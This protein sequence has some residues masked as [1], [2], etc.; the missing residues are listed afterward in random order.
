MSFTLDERL[1]ADT[2]GILEFGL[3]SVRLMRDAHYPWII[4][5]PRREGAV[6]LTD[7]TQTTATGS[8]TKSP[9]RSTR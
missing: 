9:S 4:L 2:A 8:W 3:S 7:L 5:V 1:A 6:E